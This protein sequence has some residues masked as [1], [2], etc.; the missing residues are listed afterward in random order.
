M[1]AGRA[2]PGAQVTVLDNGKPLAKTTAD[3]RGEWVVVPTQPLA[4]GDRQLSLEADTR[5]GPKVASGD[6]VAVSVAPPG[7]TTGSTNRNMAVLLPEDV[8]RPA[9]P[10]Q[11]PEAPQSPSASPSQTLSLDTAETDRQDRLALSGRAPPGATLR[12]FAGD[13]PLG[14]ATADP[15]GKW[16]LAAPRPAGSGS[17]EL[18]AEQLKPDGNV[19]VRVARAMGPA[20][21]MTVPQ[22]RRYVVRRGNN[23]WWIARRTYGEGVQYSV[24]FDANR[25]QIRDPDLIYPGQVFKLPKS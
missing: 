8:N 12:L 7:N 22:G 23:L 25:K 3:S 2:G 13:R 20:P 17:Y 24:I 15:Q 1:I 4:S 21:A 5:N 14:T 10:L 11:L 16:S 19:A 9:Q 6:S 18:R